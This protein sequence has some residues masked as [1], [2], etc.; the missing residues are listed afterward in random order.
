MRGCLKTVVFM[1]IVLAAT[2]A[3]L[4]IANDHAP[5]AVIRRTT[6]QRIVKVTEPPKP[7]RNIQ[8]VSPTS[9]R[10]QATAAP[11]VP[12]PTR[13]LPTQPSV[14]VSRFAAPRT[15][16]THGVVNLR[17][18]PDTSYDLAGSVA[19]N[20]RLQVIGES[21]QWYLLNYG[22]KEVFIAGWLTH[23]ALPQARQNQQPARQAP[24]QQ[25][26]PSFTCN[27]SKTCGQM[28]S[29]REAYFQLNNCGCRRRDSNNDG[30]PC[31]SICR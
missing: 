26:Q 13:L 25:Q 6:I 16:Y 19:A 18:G 31:E 11:V 5:S 9:T 20:S 8:S 15:R 3:A 12:T 7:E 2:A 29:C 23:D 4:Q 22:G 10:Q 14:V 30:V 21:G 28:S 24:V 17:Q 1:L 27:C